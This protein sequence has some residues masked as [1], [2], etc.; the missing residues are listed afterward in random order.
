MKSSSCRSFEVYDFNEEDDSAEV[1]AARYLGNY[2][3][4]ENPNSETPAIMKYELLSCAARGDVVKAKEID[5]VQW[6]DVDAI[7]NDDSGKCDI[8]LTPSVEGEESAGKQG[9]AQSD[10]NSDEGNAPSKADTHRSFFSVLQTDDSNDAAASPGDCRLNSDLPESPPSDEQ[11]DVTSEADESMKE[12]TL[13]SPASDT[14]EH[15]ASLDGQV[16]DDGFGN[17]DMVITL[18]V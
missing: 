2:K 8:S 17:W 12:N 5:N 18:T 3:T 10:C 4:P 14:A 1:A 9:T 11:L 16:S 15:G 7:D 13:S 6:V